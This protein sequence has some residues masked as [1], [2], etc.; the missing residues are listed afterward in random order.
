MTNTRFFILS[1]ITFFAGLSPEIYS[2]EETPLSRPH[3]MNRIHPILTTG[4]IIEIYHKGDFQG[5]VLIQRGK[6]PFGVAL[7]GGKVEWE[8]T[9]EQA[10]R[11]EMMEETGLELTHLRQFHVYSDPRR[12]ARHHSVEVTYLAKSTGNPVA[13][14]DAKE[15]FIVKIDDI[16]WSELTFDHYRILKDYLSYRSGEK[17]LGMIIP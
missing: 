13:G 4:A 1:L 5:I 11:R 3:L 2:A 12:D 14:D 8:E 10:V 16:P 7:P 6:A 15:A 17:N 9:V